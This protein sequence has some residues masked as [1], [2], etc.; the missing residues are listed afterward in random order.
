M[1]KTVNQSIGGIKD[2][3]VL[4]RENYFLKEY[5]QKSNSYAATNR[6]FL[7]Y[8][9]IPK[10]MIESVCFGGAFIMISIIAFSG[11]N[12][13][14]LVPQLSIFVLAA[15]RLLPAIARFAGYVNG[16]IFN[17]PSVDSV[18]NNLNM[19]EE[20]NKA[21]ERLTK[22]E[23]SR[24]IRVDKVSFQYPKAKDKVLEDISI[25]IPYKSSVALIGPTGSGK[26]TLADIILG[27]YEPK[28]G[29]VI[30][31]GK[32]VHHNLE[33]WKKN[34]GYIPQN[35]YLLDDTIE[36]NI[37]FGI[38]KDE[39]DNE[40]IIDVIKKAQL[41]DFVESLPEKLD[42]IVGDRGVRLSGGQKQRIGIAR[43]LYND[44]EILVLDEA[45]SS[46]DDDTEKSVM[47]AIQEFKGEKT[48][49]II[50]HRLSTIENCDI[51]F[52]VENKKVIKQGEN[53]VS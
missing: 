14:E 1:I 41:T 34:I 6:R 10:L 44:P 37:A 30:Y 16:I 33:E 19:V 11:S 8:N 15:F 38:P 27:I 52:K 22:P 24:D 36:S 25:L 47:E 32:S 40:R 51:V 29:Y 35:I 43:A 21:T 5:R 42:T 17:K 20:G 50:A 46:L 12:M 2:I 9:T 39:I 23:T 3:K 28:N 26:T 31:N 7:L 4:Q 18:Y 13:E 45:T 48:L 49:I 53:F